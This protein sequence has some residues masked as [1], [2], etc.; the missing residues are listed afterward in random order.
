[1]T[2]IASTVLL[3]ELDDAIN[4]RSPARRVE[5]LHQVTNLFLADGD[6]LN[7]VQIEVF[8]DVLVRLIER[9]EAR[10]LA[11]LSGNLSGLT[12]APRDAVRKLAFHEDVSV[13]APVLR[14][15]GRLSDEDLVEIANMRGQEHLLA[16]SG[17]DTL[18]E[19]LSDV[20]VVR[21]DSVVRST[22][23]QNSGA[24]FSEAAYVSLVRDA[25]RDDSL[26]EK[27]G[28]RQ[29]I[30]VRL[31][32]E[33]VAKAGAKVRGRILQSAPPDMLEIIKAAVAKGAEHAAMLEPKP[34][35]Y[36]ES[37]RTVFELNRKGKLND[38]FVNR[39]AVQGEYANVVAALALL[40]T[41]PIEAIES[42]IGNAQLDGLIVACKAARLNWS[43]TTMIIHNR[44]GCASA[45][46]PQV[47]RA[48]EMF[49]T[50]VLSTAQR[51]IRIWSDEKSGREKRLVG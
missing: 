27:L 13:A 5:I 16:I 37:R 40:T 35:D 43:T 10:T 34:V 24:R 18:S 1:M 3:A 38:Q 12:F 30:P 29:D 8:D 28:R 39:F 14:K 50:L 22:L 11:Q 32:Q 46:K 9:A 2:A 23:A 21:G 36:T 42:L 41:V 33:L 6:R 49:E 44:P 15:S 47:E 20:L 51:T 7:A 25:E 45:S 26:T 31:L 48:R 4:E 17:R 19:S